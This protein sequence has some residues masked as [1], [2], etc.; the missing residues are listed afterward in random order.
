MAS[1]YFHMDMFPTIMN[2]IERGEYIGIYTLRRNPQQNLSD[3]TPVAHDHKTLFQVTATFSILLLNS[4][5]LFCSLGKF[6]MFSYWFSF[7]FGLPSNFPPS[8][9][10]FF[11]LPRAFAGFA[12]VSSSAGTEGS[13]CASAGAGSMVSDG[14]SFLEDFSAFL[15]TLFSVVGFEAFFAGFFAGAGFSSPLSTVNVLS[16]I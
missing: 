8:G 5:P 14:I 15:A 1:Y 11:G 4:L 2:C 6:T 7:F 13:C 3:T 9:T 10:G 12:A 16:T